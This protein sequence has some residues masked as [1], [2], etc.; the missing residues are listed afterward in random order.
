[1]TIK[2]YPP[3]KLITTIILA[4]FSVLLVS[5]GF[6]ARAVKSAQLPVGVRLIVREVSLGTTTGRGRV[7]PRH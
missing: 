5:S 4:A 6:A 1:M 3:F 2:R 7:Q